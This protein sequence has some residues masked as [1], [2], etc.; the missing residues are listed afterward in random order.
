M[1]LRLSGGVAAVLSIA[2]ACYALPASAQGVRSHTPPTVAAGA[3]VSDNQASELTL[4]LT[5]V[6]VRPI[7]A[8]VRA[9][10]HVS[11]DGKTLRIVLPA[12]EASTVKVGQRIR[13]FSVAFR[14]QMHQGRIA[15]VTAQGDQVLLE[16]ALADDVRP[17]GARF[18]VEIVVDR[19]DYLS[20]PNVSIIEEGERHIVYVP[21]GAGKYAAKPVLTGLQGE[22]Y[23][24][25]LG[26]L[27]EGD[28]VV[29]IGSFFIDAETKLKSPGGSDAAMASMPGMDMSSMPGMD[30][31]G[32]RK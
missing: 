32:G 6:A 24:Q 11:A 31:S 26:G 17:E 23:T 8:W 25:I 16:A 18:V 20:V 10:G 13:C 4:T 9:A 30:M 15:K 28:K 2:A 21:A 7:Q 14:S 1:P 5:D 29:S 3:V 27:S 19:G 12:A 22:L